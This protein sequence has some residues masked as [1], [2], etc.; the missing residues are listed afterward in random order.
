MLSQSEHTRYSRQILLP[1]FGVAGQ[2][3]LKNSSVLVI[4]AG[5]LGCPALLYLASSGVGTI[6]IIDYDVVELSNLHRQVLFTVGDI[7]KSKSVCAA[8]HLK[9]LNPE[10]KVK[11]F[12]ERLTVKNSVE[13]ISN[14]DLILDG[15]DNFE[16]RYMI[17]DA[18]VL[19]D[20]S[21]V[22]GAVLKYSG[23]VSVLNHMLE[24]GNRTATY[25]CIFPLPPNP[26]T[27]PGCHEAGVMGF[28]PG[29]IGV[30][31][32]T[33]AIRILSGMGSALAGRLMTWDL[34]TMNV[35]TWEV[36]RNPEVWTGFPQ[37]LDEFGQMNYAYFCEGKHDIQSINNQEF[38][39][40]ISLGSQVQVL[41]VR[42]MDELPE[43]PDLNRYRIPMS[44]LEN[45]SGELDPANRWVVLCASGR[46]SKLAI[47]LLKSKYPETEFLN[48]ENGLQ[49]WMLNRH[50]VK[51]G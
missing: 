41:D 30:M 37:S 45:R 20:K 14:Y 27:T 2:E 39:A 49:G 34:K 50:T 4:G 35:Q 28:V 21:L 31:Q 17:N 36:S 8:Q 44:E 7:G 5:G 47:R 46:R 3:K 1:G 26:E 13:Y 32:A 15:T 9:K 12:E 48:L 33:E 19:L 40:L 29:L 24:N 38:D 25:R 16:T 22:Y 18:C 11:A 43:L 6:G 51:H 42:E 10:I 23:Q